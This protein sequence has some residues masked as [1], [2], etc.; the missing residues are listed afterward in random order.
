[1]TQENQGKNPLIFVLVSFLHA[2][3]PPLQ[4]E[5]ETNKQLLT[6][7]SGEL[8]YL[9]LNHTMDFTTKYTS[10]NI[11]FSGVRQDYINLNFLQ[12]LA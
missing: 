7:W 4:K 9:K 1:M 3:S 8:A 2:D 12:N 10:Q 6:A 11:L 5:K